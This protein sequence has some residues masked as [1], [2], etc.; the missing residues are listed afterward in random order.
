MKS[1][2]S[3]PDTEAIA[4]HQRRETTSDGLDGCETIFDLQVCVF[5]RSITQIDSSLQMESVVRIKVCLEWM[6][7]R[8]VVL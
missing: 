8:E 1:S 5:E 7:I 4:S 6:E 3:S 2:R